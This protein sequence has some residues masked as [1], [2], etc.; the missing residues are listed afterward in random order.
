MKCQNNLCIYWK[1]SMCILN[2]ITLDERGI[3]Q[4]CICVNISENL[5]KIERKSMLKKYND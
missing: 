2:E 4:E 5:L 1:N 3:C